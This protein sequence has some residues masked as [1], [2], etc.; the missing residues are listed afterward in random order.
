MHE[1]KSIF[2]RYFFISIGCL[3]FILGTVGIIFPILP[4]VPFYM[5]TVFCFA[6]G[7]EKLERW[8]KGTDLYK[9]HLEIFEQKRQMRVDTKLKI[10]STV[11]ILMAGAIYLMPKG[12]I[13]GYIVI[14]LIWFIHV[15]YF[16][17]SVKNAK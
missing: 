17:F 3:S 13:V 14:G 10:I 15:F 11:T 16:I 4:T 12:L 5:L 1:R 2:T 9:N 8:F 7:S 6:K